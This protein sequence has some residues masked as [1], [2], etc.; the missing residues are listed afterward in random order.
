MAE[1]PRGVTFDLEAYAV[2]R[3]GARRF[4]YEYNGQARLREVEEDLTGAMEIPVVGSIVSRSGQE[5]KV[6]H[7]LAPVS[8]L[9]TV[10]VVRV[11]LSNYIKGAPFFL[12]RTVP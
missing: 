2:A 11:F 10:P 12:N 1:S 9:G 7:V 8:L 5:W 3:S 4:I 6:I